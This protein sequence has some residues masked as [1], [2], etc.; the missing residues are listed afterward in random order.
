MHMQG[1]LVKLHTIAKVALNVHSF[2]QK[3]IFREVRQP[4]VL[5]RQA[6]RNVSD[7]LSLL[8]T[9]NIIFHAPVARRVMQPLNRQQIHKLGF[10]SF[11]DSDDTSQ[12]I[13]QLAAYDGNAFHWL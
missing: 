6:Y 7:L 2:M 10:W 1:V 13:A 11:Y 8:W 5:T 4:H 3:R 12:L 9:G